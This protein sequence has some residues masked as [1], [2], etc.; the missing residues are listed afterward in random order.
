[1]TPRR[2][3]AEFLLSHPRAYLDRVA[4]ENRPLELPIVDAQKSKRA[5]GRVVNPQAACHGE[6]EQT[7]RDR[8]AKESGLGKLVVDVNRVEVAAEAGEVDDIG[9][10]HGAAERFPLLPDRHIVKIK[11]NA[12]N[13]I[14]WRRDSN[15][16]GAYAPPDF[17]TTIAFATQAVRS[18]DFLLAVD[19]RRRP[20]PLSLYT[21]FLP[22]RTRRPC[23]AVGQR[24]I[25]ADRKEAW[26]GIAITLTC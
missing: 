11:M 7:V 10:R 14:C 23:T 13:D 3:R 20:Q 9:L 2:P 12:V 8:L 1:M 17:H 24:G 15:P 18:L 4:D 22:P 16:H 19:V 26:L 25:R 6:D 21:F 5:H